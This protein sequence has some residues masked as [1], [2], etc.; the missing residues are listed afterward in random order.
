MATPPFGGHRTF[1]WFTPR[2]RAATEYEL[3]TVGQQS[4]PAQWLHVGWPIRF[5]DGREPYT[6]SSTAIGCGNWPGYRDPAG[7]WQRPYVASANHTEQANM[8]LSSA[9]LIP[10]LQK[11]RMSSVENVPER[12]GYDGGL[13]HDGAGHGL[14][15]PL[16]VELTP[17]GLTATRRPR[18]PAPRRSAPAEP[19]R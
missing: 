4:D 1:I 14:L 3:Y 17:A 19:G 16:R 12:N 15:P 9:L 18:R 5:D 13:S 8:P 11:V 7:L 10:C 6:A 2:R